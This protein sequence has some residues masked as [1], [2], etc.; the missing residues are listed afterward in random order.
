MS[1]CPSQGLPSF[2]S[3]AHPF[4]SATTIALPHL[5]KF[6]HSMGSSSSLSCVTMS[7]LG[8]ARRAPRWTR[9]FDLPLPSPSSP[10]PDIHD[11]DGTEHDQ[12]PVVGAVLDNGRILLSGVEFAVRHGVLKSHDAD[13]RAKTTL[14]RNATDVVLDMCVA[15]ARLPERGEGRDVWLCAWTAARHGMDGHG[16]AR[17][18]GGDLPLLFRHSNPRREHLVPPDVVHDGPSPLSLTCVA[19]AGTP[20]WGENREDWL[21]SWTAGWMVFGAHASLE[22]ASSWGIGMEWR[23]GEGLGFGPWYKAAP[24]S[25]TDAVAPRQHSLD[26]FHRRL[27]APLQLPGIVVL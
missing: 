8:R 3:H 11:S 19:C 22:G 25:P 18:V 15:C 23:W 14:R 17:I 13:S 4:F 9:V 7:R 16:G 24:L 21:G 27:V 26:S 20:E 1:R 5:L 12:H 10:L 2:K 6:V